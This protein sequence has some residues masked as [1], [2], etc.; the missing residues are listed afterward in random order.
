MAHTSSAV[1]QTVVQLMRQVERGPPDEVAVEEAGGGRKLTI[2]A[3]AEQSN[4]L[5]NA[6]IG[7]GLD[8]GDRVA[9]VAQN[10]L[11]YVVL[12]F[13][14]LKAGLVKVPLN[15]RFAPHELR[16]CIE[17]ADVRLIVADPARRQRSTRSSR[18]RDRA[19]S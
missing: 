19:A 18:T 14:L 5:A 16:R 11:E 4:R 9:Y 15:P 1:A 8:A 7:L 17:L 2:G 6:F 3:L 13:A 12:E 10:H